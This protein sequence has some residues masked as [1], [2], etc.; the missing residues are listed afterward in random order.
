MNNE[1]ICVTTLVSNSNGCE[2]G[3]DQSFAKTFN[4]LQAAGSH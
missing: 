1:G 4:D 2:Y 3:F